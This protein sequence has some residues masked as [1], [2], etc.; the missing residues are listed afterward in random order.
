MNTTDRLSGAFFFLAGL[1]LYFHVIPNYVDVVD[2]GAIHPATMPN[3]LAILLSICGAALILRPTAQQP[4]D[5]RLML[6]AGLYLAVLVAGIAAMSWFHF[7]YVAPP[8][9]LAI[10][11]L[12][13]ER[14][15]LWLLTG[16]AVIPF[17]I[18]LV[19]RVALDR[20]LP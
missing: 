4:P 14:R 19:V 11:L 2:Y 17:L 16:V 6:R 3:A 15:P 10:M 20:S 5:L 18:W 1:A 13:G 8:L 12:I 9:A 7:V